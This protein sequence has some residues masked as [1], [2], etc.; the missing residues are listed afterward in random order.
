MEEL[1]VSK[2][3]TSIAL[4]GKHAMETLDFHIRMKV[5]KDKIYGITGEHPDNFDGIDIELL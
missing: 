5:I 3:S 2:I 1:D 4:L